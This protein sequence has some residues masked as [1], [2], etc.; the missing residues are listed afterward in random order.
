MIKIQQRNIKQK[1]TSIKRNT[2]EFVI[3]QKDGYS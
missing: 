2:V 3:K 1:E